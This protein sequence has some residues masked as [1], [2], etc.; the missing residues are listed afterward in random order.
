MSLRLILGRAGSGK[1]TFIYQEISG[2]IAEDPQGPPLWLLVPEQA[3]SQAERNL[4][5]AGPMAGLMRAR[6]VS[7]QRLAYQLLH[8]VAGAAL[9][10][11]GELGRH[12]IIRRVIEQHKPELSAFYRAASQPGFTHKLA[13]LISEL[14]SCQVSPE[15][16][17]AVLHAEGYSLSP[18]LQHKLH[19][20]SLLYQQLAEQYG[21]TYLDS[22]DCLNLLAEN[23]PASQSVSGNAIWLDGFNGFTAQ[24]YA[25][26]ERLL[27]VCPQVTVSLTLPP[28]LL[29]ARLRDDDVFYSPWST[30]K[31]LQRR[32]LQL[33]V[34]VEPFLVPSAVSLRSQGQADLQY[35]EANYFDRLQPPFAGTP[36]SLQVVA[37]SNRRAEVE[38]A[39]AEII[40]LCRD[41]GYR[42]RNISV[43]LRDFS[44]YD[45][46][47]TSVFTDFGIPHFL[48]TKR[49]VD[50]HP[51]LELVRSAVETVLQNFLYEPVFRCLKTDLFPL[52]RDAVDQLE[53]YVL[54]SGIRGSKRWLDAQDWL[55]RASTS[56]AADNLNPVVSAEH[57]KQLNETRQ[58]VKDHLGRLHHGLLAASTVRQYATAIYRFLSELK[59]DET[60]FAWA[61]QA[62][63]RGELEAAG[64]HTQVWSALVGLLDELVAGLDGE[65]LP[66]SEFARVLD[67]GLETI[68]LGLIPPELDQVVVTSLG[69]SRNP[70]VKAALVLGVSE[71]VL[72]ARIPDDGLFT[73]YERQA[74]AACQ[75]ELGPSPERRLFDEQYLVYSAI[76]RPSQRLWLSYPLAD[77]E[78]TTL[79]PSSLIKRVRELFPELPLKEHPLTPE[80]L[81]DSAVLSYLCHPRPALRMLAAELREASLGRPVAA[82]WWDVYSHLL[83]SAAERPALLRLLAGMERQNREVDLA[84]PLV[85]RLYG[86]TLRAS[87]SR[88][89][90]YNACPFA[91]FATY[92]LR[93]KERAIY[94]LAAPD[95]GTFFH[96]AMDRF[97]IELQR[98]NL[99]W[100]ELS[101][102][103][104]SELT[105]AIVDELSPGLQNHIL[106]SS[107]RFRHIAKKLQRTVERSARILGR[108]ASRGKFQPVAVELAFGPGGRIPGLSFTLSDGTRIE[109]AGRIDRLDVAESES[110][111]SY[112]RVIDYKSGSSHLTPLEVYYGLKMQLLTYLH[113]AKTCAADLLPTGA[114]EAGALYFRVHDPLQ[115]SAAP[116]ALA[117]AEQMGL[118]AYRM[119]GVLL[120]DV[121]AVS[122]M[123]NQTD[124]RSL[125][126]PVTFKSDGS[127]RPSDQVWSQ[128]ELSRMRQHLEYLF[129]VAGE[130][131]MAGDISIA[132]YRLDKETACRFCSLSAVCQFDPLLPENGYRWLNKLSRAEV[133]QRLEQQQSGGVEDER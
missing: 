35:L 52:S 10:Q 43:T 40:R 95:L 119:Q 7:F 94:Q 25:V 8:E 84:R 115:T 18:T 50:D 39:A 24:E 20:L 33:G 131:I 36:T 4:A 108:H 125:L 126:I 71:G 133:M 106:D 109:L 41:E 74:L 15:D 127:I 22:A 31:E 58:V 83:S 72:P 105:R 128:Q 29:A 30:A 92:G 93:L 88:I 118:E 45:Y 117:D 79:L 129:T 66:L 103:Q 69:R 17:L 12:M 98:R 23:L 26:I 47:L 19:D 44:N 76:T 56:E 6:V 99:N 54:A 63:E 91:F 90:R 100:G 130:Q 111:Q 21:D 38:A 48:D 96:D 11:V 112:L 16:L 89:E 51:A 116:V 75:L 46:L 73:H 64:L 34:A 107:S 5:T 101:D 42:Y 97:V 82:I 3:T 62:A 32:A 65:E 9:V 28:N 123:D 114:T 77:E 67:S 122:L 121:S 120:D 132:P 113:V 68:E 59:V 81:A 14:K 61:E 37:A 85:H 1:S 86:Q 102:N 70:E 80:S 13:Q 104:Y 53:N 2:L 124:G 57:T 49:A 110:G 87:V 78:G 60:L 27:T 55:P